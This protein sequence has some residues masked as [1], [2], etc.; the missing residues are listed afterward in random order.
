MLMFYLFVISNFAP[1]L[2]VVVPSMRIFFAFNFIL[3]LLNT[4]GPCGFVF[5]T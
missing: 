1:F 2:T 5:V 4:T 3:P